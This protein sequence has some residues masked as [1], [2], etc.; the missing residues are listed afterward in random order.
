MN[1]FYQ[2]EIRPGE[3]IL[4]QE[5]SL[6]AVKVL[7]LKE[8]D[9]VLVVDGKGNRYEGV[10]RHAHPKQC[11]V[12]LNLVIRDFEKRNYRLHI[13]VAPTKNSERTDWFLEK[14]T[15][16]GI[17][18]FSPLICRHSERKQV[19]HA[20]MEKIAISAMKQSR[21]AFLPV[22]NPE[23]PFEK[24][25]T[26]PFEGAKFIAHCNAGEKPCLKDLVLSES[27]I[28]VLIGP[29]GD[30]SPEEVNLARA[31]GFQEVSLGNSILRT[32]TAALVACHTV[33]LLNSCQTGSTK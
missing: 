14:A 22:I 10:I 23:I 7:R 30:F 27:Q 28:L 12:T 13:G 16:I 3:A 29:E 2:G 18:E 11:L 31:N 15:E 1:I 21:K 32:E 4:G 5:E 33:A 9:P 6:H 20:R 24:F 8:G 19:N 25:V 26:L 17:D